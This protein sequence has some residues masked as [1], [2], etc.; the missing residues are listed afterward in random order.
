MLQ[1]SSRT[2]KLWL[3]YLYHID[4][5]RLFIR[6]DRIGNWNL[7]LISVK[8][9]INLFVAI[10]HIDYTTCARLHQQNMLELKNTHPRV[11]QWFKEGVL[12]TVRRSDK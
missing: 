11:Y 8:K 6:G 3:K 9:G 1:D 2:A 12:C 4:I 10:E 7:Y 5:V